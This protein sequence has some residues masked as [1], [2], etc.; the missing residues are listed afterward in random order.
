MSI[1]KI[2]ERIAVLRRQK[3]ITQ[4]EL[5]R[6]VGI[7]A[8]A[9]S[10]WENG[11]VPDT[12]LLPIIA[13]YFETSIDDLFGRNSVS[14]QW[15]DDAIDHAVYSDDRD[16]LLHNIFELCWK[17]E[18][19]TRQNK[20]RATLYRTE[21]T[22]NGVSEKTPVFSSLLFDGGFTQMLI[23][24]G[25]KYFICVPE[26]PDAKKITDGV[27]LYDLFA[28]LSKR[29]V[30][31]TMIMLCKRDLSSGNFT[32]EL[33][34]SKMNYDEE[35]AAEVISVL[36]KYHFLG[37]DSLE[38]NDETINTYWIQRTPAACFVS[39]L[40]FAHDLAEKPEWFFIYHDN[41]YKAF[42]K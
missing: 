17:M 20:D 29:E 19:S 26:N 23:N 37:T 33:I 35:K 40:L 5:A 4:E 2:G 31:D 38:L 28:D 12:E 34:Q 27:D 15:F 11:S 1:M 10:K 24:N 39:L 3:G 22:T 25:N 36:R 32:R 30:L 41:K 7:T 18:Q 42:L 13:D 8:Q 9:V 14:G 21:E 6:N 16:Q